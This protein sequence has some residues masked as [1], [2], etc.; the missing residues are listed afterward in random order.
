VEELRDYSID[1]LLTSVCGVAPKAIV[2]FF[3]TRIV[4][5]IALEQQGVDN[6]YETI[7]NNTSWSV[8]SAAQ[9]SKDYSDALTAFVDLMK[10]YSRYEDRLSVI[11]WH[12]ADIWPS[13]EETGTAIFA[14]LDPLLHNSESEDALL[15][16]RSL[17]DAPLGLDINH[18]MFALH[19]LWTC[20]AFGEEMK[21]AAMNRLVS[22]YFASG[23]VSAVQ[24]GVPIMVHSGLAEPWRQ[25]V[26][27]LLSHCEPGSL[28]FELY[29]RIS[30]T[31]PVY[32]T[33]DFPD[34]S[35]EADETD[36]E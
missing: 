9:H 5:A 23:G 6:D 30:G 4:H 28:A 32:Q 24:P 11:F 17:D 25:E 10:R 20:S 34:P 21:N 8:F 7:P 12:M 35:E 27:E 2:S 18:P 31:E 29:S 13:H 3:E 22:K 36:D 1:G 15:V 26:T 16:V 14:A 19:V 33:L